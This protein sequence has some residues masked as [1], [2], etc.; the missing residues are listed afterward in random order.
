MLLKCIADEEASSERSVSSIQSGEPL[1][2]E[3]ANTKLAPPFVCDHPSC[4]NTTIYKRK[5][6]LERHQKRHRS[7]EKGSWYCGCCKLE[8]KTYKSWRKDHVSQ[9]LRGKH[10]LEVCNPGYPCAEKL[11]CKGGTLLFSSTCCLNE[12]LVLEHGPGESN[13]CH[14]G[15]RVN[16]VSITRNNGV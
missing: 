9:H 6:D 1:A 8:G 16:N 12:H 15:E 13:S 10:S 14:E 2:T 7:E 4:K 11:C 5:Y 3:K